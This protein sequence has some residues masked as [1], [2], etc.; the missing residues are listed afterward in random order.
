MATSPNKTPPKDAIGP[1]A[2]S[3]TVVAI[4]ETMAD[5]M[6]IP[7]NSLNRPAACALIM[8]VRALRT[9][10]AV[11]L[12]AAGRFKELAGIGIVSAIVSL[13]ATTVLLLAAGPIASLGG[14]L[15]GE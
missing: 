14:V 13:I 5:T 2:R 15:L 3:K 4:R 1:A 8:V 7:A 9:P 11:L 6:P 10:L 12:Q